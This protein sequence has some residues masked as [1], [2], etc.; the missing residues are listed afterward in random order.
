MEI[1]KNKL[2]L[3]SSINQILEISAENLTNTMEHG[4][5]G[6]SGIEDKVEELDYSDKMNKIISEYEYNIQDLWDT[7]KRTSL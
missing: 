7:I 4:K 6:I 2:K 1:L 5:D 3:K